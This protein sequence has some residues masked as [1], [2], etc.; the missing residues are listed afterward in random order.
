M[1]AAEKPT[2]ATLLH[3][4]LQHS[5]DHIYFKDR[6]SR[7]TLVN[8]R[9]AAWLDLS[10][11]EGAVGRT[12][13]DFFSALHARAARGDEEALLRG[14]VPMVAK[15]ERE[16]WP[17]G[18]ETWVSTIKLPLRDP[19]GR[20]V[21]TFG[22]SR[23]ITEHK[24]QEQA[25]VKAHRRLRELESIVNRSGAV[26][27]LWRMEDDWPIEYVSDNFTLFGYVPAELMAAQTPYGQFIHPDDR[28]ALRQSMAAFVAE[29]RSEYRLH[30]RLR[31]REGAERWV[32][33]HGL[34][35][36]N[37]EGRPSR[38]QGIVIDV[39]ERHAAEAELE[40]YRTRL[41]SMVAERTR[42]WEDANRQLLAE[43][44]ERQRRSIAL[45]ESEERYR[46]LLASV[47]DY[48]YEVDIEDGRVARTRHG[49]GCEAVTGYTTED[50]ER[51][52]YL[53]VQMV[54]EDERPMVVAQTRSLLETGETPPLEHR[55]RHRDGSLRWVRN[56][57]VAKRDD[58]GRLVGYDGLIKDITAERRAE[59]ARMAMEREV[60][61]TRQRE[62]LERA[63]RLSVLGFLATGV[64]HEV[65][66]PLQAM[67]SHLH[68]VH[69]TLPADFARRPSLDVL[70]R[71]IESIAALVR[72]LL[73]LGAES[74]DPDETSQVGDALAFVRELLGP[75]LD[76]AGIGLDC[77]C[78]AACVSLAVPHKDLVQILL[79]LIMNAR[80]ATP[81]GGTIA[82]KCAIEEGEAVLRV[83]DTGAGI[84][85]DVLPRIFSLFFT[86][87][88]KKGTGLGLS[89][90]ESLVRARRGRIGVESEVGKGTTVTVRFP[91]VASEGVCDRK[92]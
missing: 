31:T 52:P 26:L 9:M 3:A 34:I 33:E 40:A 24:R 20:I 84:P 49:P 48:V 50:Y 81:A 74:Q 60:M 21:G 56:T 85:P 69:A 23:D 19:D 53:W 15:E 64:A 89:I 29:G 43:A 63:D 72:R 68:A 70:E 32:D 92:S 78:G 37:A 16:T 47:T 80:D 46:R 17:D 62:V 25:L 75:Q 73:W 7:F 10:D 27:F 61:E 54:P 13:A 76:R 58:D 88:G 91:A 28:P 90:V 12:D 55:I 83:T 79:N 82:L 59:E 44:A 39:S 66:N 45:R 42:Q 87:K 77:Q 1:N 14:D 51:D 6:E 35:L 5:A 67:L 57:A 2:E 86:T 41:E 22:V 65:N 4:L 8:P 18:R 38:V 30:Y 11:P 36:R 71:G